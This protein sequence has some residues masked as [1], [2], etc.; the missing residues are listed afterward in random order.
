MKAARVGAGGDL[1]RRLLI[2]LVIAT[3]LPLV[4]LSWISLRKYESQLTLEWTARLAERT[5]TAGLAIFGRLETLRSDVALAAAGL[6]PVSGSLDL[7]A[8]RAGWRDRFVSL[9]LVSGPGAQGAQR[10]PALDPAALSRLRDGRS[11]LIVDEPALEEPS[12][13]LV[14]PR[15]P[16]SQELIWGRARIDWVWPELAVEAGG[17]EGL[18]LFASDR[19]KPIASSAELPSGLLS[20]VGMAPGP[21][22]PGFEWRDANG[23]R[24]LARFWSVPLGFEFGHPGLTVLI[25]EPFRLWTSIIEIRRLL[26]LLTLGSLLLIVLVGIRRLRS[27]LGPLEKLAETALLMANGDLSVRVE[28]GRRDE[29]GRL[30]DAFNR[31]AIELERRFHQVEGTRNIAA[32]A[33]V[34]APSAEDV[35]REF[36]AQAVPLAGGLEV[37]VALVD[38][39]GG[40]RRTI[41]TSGLESGAGGDEDFARV[42]PPVAARAGA[43]WVA[44]GADSVWRA[45]GHGKETFALVGLLGGRVEEREGRTALL[46]GA[47]DHLALAFA[48]VRV[49][50]DL[51]R[52]NWGALTALARAV[53]AK[54][55]W[56]LGH[57]VR[58]AEIAAAIA[59]DAGWSE[60]DIRRIR[61]GCLVHD[62]GKIGVP[63]AVLDK[64]GKL[65]E[66]EV[67]ILRSH[68]EKGAR[69]LEPIPGLAEVL[70][71]VWQ[72]HER[73][74]GSGYP[75]GLY[76]DEIDPDA[77]LVAVADVFEALTVARPYRAAWELE[78]V[79][80]YLRGLAGV[81][82]DAAAVDGLF[83]IC[84]R[85]GCWSGEPTYTLLRE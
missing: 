36:V 52:A 37:V 16:S 3:W 18:L 10:L 84:H 75:N 41:S 71:I 12:V 66:A 77:A 70:P 85:H 45:L 22:S 38:D 68:V 64:A 25:S 51:E 82:F 19:H 27:D 8:T 9:I 5:K 78:R 47:C 56:T 43:G 44:G 57:S 30:S 49:L 2:L 23:R 69:I 1:S 83:R 24:F 54:S 20:E 11:V 80:G 63:N 4:L 62:V 28:V 14:S 48:H 15:D 7:L 58:V 26:L 33:L 65:D 35:A 39:A 42:I 74:D 73:L 17:G 81:Q 13:W 60:R 40:I 46:N 21:A 6:P 29:V 55:A 32:S 31:M 72:H 61:R 34:A 53:D 79:E 59:T 50:E 67:A 76:G